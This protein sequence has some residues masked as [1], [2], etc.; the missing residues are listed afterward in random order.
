MVSYFLLNLI[1]FKAT[2][3]KNPET[4]LPVTYEY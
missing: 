2:E 1:T 4:S 3:E